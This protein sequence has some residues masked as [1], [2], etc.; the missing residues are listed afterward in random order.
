VA[1]LMPISGS[2]FLVAARLCNFPTGKATLLSGHEEWIQGDA[3]RAMASS[4]A[5]WIDIVAYASKRGDAQFNMQLSGARCEAVK[6]KT[7]QFHPG[8]MFNVE[9][10]KGETESAGAENDNDGYWRA[11]DVYVYGVRPTA[12]V[13]PPPSPVPIMGSTQFEIRVVGGGSGSIVIQTDNYFF[14]IVNLTERLTAFYF[15]TG[16]GIGLS[17][18]KIPGPGSVTKAGPPTRFHTTRP[19]Q[20]HAFNSR[21]SLYQDPGATVGPVSV[22]GTMRLAL[23]EVLDNFGIVGTR[24]STIPIGGGAGI[25]MPGLGSASEGVLA[26]SSAVFPFNGYGA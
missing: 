5:P 6:A 4:R 14:Q 19:V 7:R 15:Y 24:P 2:P 22:G 1:D 16:A 13:R 17:I 12:P 10:H 20:L 11:A 3:R 25:Q 21:A 26:L 9:L 18:P 23:R 8:A